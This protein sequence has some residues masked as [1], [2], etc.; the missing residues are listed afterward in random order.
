MA[1]R[2]TNNRA[3]IGRSRA[4]FRRTNHRASV[5]PRCTRLASTLLLLFFSFA[6]CR[7]AHAE[8]FR[9]PCGGVQCTVYRVDLATQQLELFYKNEKGERFANA[10][11]LEEWG[12][13]HGKKL[14]FATNAGIFSTQ[15]SPLGLFVSGGREIVPLNT[16]DGEGNFYLKPNGVFYV[17]D[18]KAKVRK[19]KVF[20]PSKKVTLATQSGPMLL[21]N[22]EIHPRFKKGSSNTNIR[23][24]VGVRSDYE[25]I[26][27]ISDGQISM[28]DLAEVFRDTLKCN[29]ALYLDG[30]ISQLYLPELSRME[31]GGDFAGQFAVFEPL[32]H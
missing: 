7:G 17:E 29:D 19:S 26:F 10:A 23:S 13:A 25:A 2:R 18:G 21:I 15:T 5:R 27:V 12:R 20:V 16:R 1:L 4:R 6:L 24:G 32:S 30:A 14:V 22:G 9:V 31:R 3:I 11:G 8:G 28:F